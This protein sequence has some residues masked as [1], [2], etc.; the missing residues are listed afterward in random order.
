V[1][2]AQ[3]LDSIFSI[4]LAKKETKK[5]EDIDLEILGGEKKV[6]NEIFL[7]NWSRFYKLFFVTFSR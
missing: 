2:I 7:L 3:T 1:F 5:V 4:F 6:W